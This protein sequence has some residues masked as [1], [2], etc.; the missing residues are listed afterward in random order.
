MLYRL[1]PYEE[2]IEA[3]EEYMEY[4]GGS[5]FITALYNTINNKLVVKEDMYNKSKISMIYPY[6]DKPVPFDIRSQS[7]EFNVFYVKP[8]WLVPAEPEVDVEFSGD[9]LV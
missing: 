5:D 3:Q 9:V 2:N 7:N 1:I 6:G 4:N 8:E